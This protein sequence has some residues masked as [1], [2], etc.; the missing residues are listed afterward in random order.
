MR[1]F[2][3]AVAGKVWRTLA[4]KSRLSMNAAFRMA[5]SAFRIAGKV[6]L[7]RNKNPPYGRMIFRNVGI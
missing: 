3:G 7:H 4:G 6:S 2:L 5:S 1:F